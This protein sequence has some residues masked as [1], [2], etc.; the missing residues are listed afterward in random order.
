MP[1]IDL[2]DVEDAAGTSS[3]EFRASMKVSLIFFEG[4]VL[5]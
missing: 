3:Q 5:M 1:I 2:I 4:R